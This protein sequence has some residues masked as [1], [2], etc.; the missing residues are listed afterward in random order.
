VSGLAV[1]LITGCALLPAPGSEEPTPWEEPRISIVRID[2]LYENVHPSFWPEGS[3]RRGFRLFLDI[4]IFLDGSAGWERDVR[5]IRLHDPFGS[6]WEIPFDSDELAGTGV[7]G[8]WLRL[9]DSFMSDNGAMLPLRGMHVQVELADGRVVRHTLDAPPPAASSPDERFLV[10]EEYRG[11]LTAAHVFALPRAVVREA[12]FEGQSLRLELDPV[13]RRVTNGQIVLLDRDRRL[14]AE[15]PEFYNDISREPRMLLNG[16]T[17]LRADGSN[18]VIVPTDELAVA[19]GR[20]VDEARFAY[21]KL[22]DG[23]QFAFTERS[24]AYVHLS[25]SQLVDLR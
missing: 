23:A 7:A 22:R 17:R 8:G 10:S 4:W 12:R 6:H 15:S 19:P 20:S 16:G 3:S 21:V 13:D 24:A 1:L 18:G 9:R 5:A 25:R 11:D 2:A 14:V